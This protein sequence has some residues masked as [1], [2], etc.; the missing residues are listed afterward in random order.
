MRLSGRPHFL[1]AGFLPIFPDRPGPPPDCWRVL[2]PDQ[3]APQESSERA[4]EM[5]PSLPPP[6]ATWWAIANNRLGTL[7]AWARSSSRRRR[8]P[9]ASAPAPWL[10]REAAPRSSELPPASPGSNRELH[11]PKQKT[12]WPKL[13]AG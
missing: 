8:S 2:S 6:R 11:L 5:P 9:R 10:P 3:P 4:R 7:D 12:E 13:A 1:L